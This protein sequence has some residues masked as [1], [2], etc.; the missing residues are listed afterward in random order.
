MLFKKSARAVAPPEA[1]EFETLEELKNSLKEQLKTTKKS[2]SKM[3][4]KDRALAALIELMDLKELPQSLVQQEFDHLLR[5]FSS[6][7]EAQGIQLEQY[8]TITGTTSDQLV[9]QILADAQN[10][11]RVDL[12]LRALVREEAVQVAAEDLE[13]EIRAYA[14]S[15]QIEFDEFRDRITE[16]GQIK[17]IELEMAKAKALDQFLELVEIA[18]EDG[19]PVSRE[20]MAETDAKLEDDLV[21]GSESG[22]DGIEGSSGGETNDSV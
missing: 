8:L 2:R 5:D 9:S 13:K 11:A 17:V 10:Q 7:L 16:N 3:L 19:N 18:D 1:S 22:K 21:D 15:G 20:F 14:E 12:V 6:R 4:F